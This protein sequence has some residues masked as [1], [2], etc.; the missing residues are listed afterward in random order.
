MALLVAERETA[1]ELCRDALA[2]RDQ[3][4]ADYQSLGAEV[5]KLTRARDRALACEAAARG[6]LAA[7][8]SPPSPADAL[9]QEARRLGLDYPPPPEVERGKCGA[10]YG[11]GFH[12][13]RDSICGRCGGIGREGTK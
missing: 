2:E 1:R 5:L 6:L 3:A 10:C 11:S 8:S 7:L 9:S 12:G 4:L 13:A